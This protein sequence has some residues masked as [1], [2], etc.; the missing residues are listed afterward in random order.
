[1]TRLE[2][3]LYP[4]AQSRRCA[5]D[6]LAR[7]PCGI[8]QVPKMLWL[9]QHLP[10]AFE[11]VNRGGKFLDL[12]DYLAYRATDCTQDVRSLCTVVCK[13]T[14]DANGVGSG[15]GFDRDFLAQCGFAAEE[16]T[17]QTIGAVVAAPGEAVP[18]GLGAEAA[19]RFGLLPGTALAVGMIDAHSG[20]IGSLGAALP[21]QGGAA[22]GAA[23]APLS[24]RL[25]L[26]AGTSTCH[27]ASSTAPCF[28]PGVWGPYW[29]AMAPD[30][31]LNEGGQS[32]AGSLLDHLVEGHVAYAELS[33]VAAMAGVPPTI[34]LNAHLDG[35]A[36]AA[37]A[38]VADLAKDVH[39]T[40]DALGNRSPL[41]DPRM[42]G[43]V[44][45]FGLSAT[46]DDLAVLYLAAVQSLAYQT[47]H[48]VEALEAADH[49][50][51]AHVIACGGL[52]KNSLYVGTHADVLGLPVHL[53]VQEEAV[54]LGAGILG[55]AAGSAHPS[56]AVAMERMS[57]IGETVQPTTEVGESLLHERK[58]RVFRRMTDDQLEYRRIMQGEA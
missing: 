50:P 2:R 13:W 6:G 39:V 30:L 56:I 37:S 14:Y 24:S 42:R 35:M 7:P 52:S 25:A 58:Y 38:S 48:I 53:P 33:E 28:V 44:V 45:G 34:A 19:A 9:K 54:L 22:S 32:A 18:G 57:A 1:M 4:I 23:A 3:R 41:A 27:M 40:P 47:K 15:L 12:A 46:L 29:N 11:L 49:P 36:A 26:I 8:M 20:G 21:G 10:D 17:P 43:A 51:I 16:L 31:Y 5:S 55:A